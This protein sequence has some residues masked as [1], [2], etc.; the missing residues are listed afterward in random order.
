VEGSPEMGLGFR[1]Q[2][3]HAPDLHLGRRTSRAPGCLFDSDR[4]DFVH[5]SFGV[6]EFDSSNQEI[7]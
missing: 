4:R 7:R 6:S 1:N 2:F 3:C 5:D